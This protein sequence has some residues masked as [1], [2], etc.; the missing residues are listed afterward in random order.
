MET[1]Q[2]KTLPPKHLVFPRECLVCGEGL[3]LLANEPL[4][5]L[6]G[7]PVCSEVCYGIYATWKYHRRVH[8]VE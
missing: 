2:E 7:Y 4:S 5:R 1:L 3:D 6:L 8:N